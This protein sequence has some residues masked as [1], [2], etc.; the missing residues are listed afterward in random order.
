MAA[1]HLNRVEPSRP[2][3]TLP[4]NLGSLAHHRL[5]GLLPQ[6]SDLVAYRKAREETGSSST[7]KLTRTTSM[8]GQAWE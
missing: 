5:S 6:T 3:R 2:P 8:A 1:K 7:F 4:A